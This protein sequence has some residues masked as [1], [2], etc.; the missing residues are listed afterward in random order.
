[1]NRML[2]RGGL[3]L[4]VSLSLGYALAAPTTVVNQS[5]WKQVGPGPTWVLPANLAGIGCGAENETTCEPHGQFAFNKAFTATQGYFTIVESG[6][7]GSDQVTF[8]NSGAGGNGV[9]S[10]YSDP[11]LLTSAQLAAFT[12]DGILC[13]EG[14]SSGCVS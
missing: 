5:I 14:A 3:A 6:G 9:I 13:T 8:G 1:M 2:K 7:T 11:T 10:F 12:F 4:L